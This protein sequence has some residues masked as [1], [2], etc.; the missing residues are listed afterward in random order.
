MNFSGCEAHQ[1][2]NSWLDRW[3]AAA[4]VC[5]AAVLVHSARLWLQLN[6]RAIFASSRARIADYDDDAGPACRV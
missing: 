3:L 4:A 5:L 2:L 1:Q 6:R